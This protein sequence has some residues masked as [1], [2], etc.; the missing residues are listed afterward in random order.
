MRRA[1]LVTLLANARAQRR[2]TR[3][4]AAV[5]HDALADVATVTELLEPLL[6]LPVQEADLEALRAIQREVVAIVA[7]LIDGSQPPLEELNALAQRAP[8]VHE[9][10][11]GPDGSL[12]GRLRP[13]PASAT[14]SLL[15]RVI[16]ELAELDCSRLRRCAR[17]ECRLVFYD[18]TRS[19]TQR[20]HAERPC[21]LRERQRRH[22][23]R[24]RP[25]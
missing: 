9:L 19:G 5:P 4:P 22:R 3:A 23:A 24:H 10:R 13:T 15:A 16:G 2:P 25:G 17:P 7:A 1:P 12:I 20:W 6:D 14:A 21:G 8:A 18:T 11:V